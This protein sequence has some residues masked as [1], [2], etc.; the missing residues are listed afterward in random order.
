MIAIDVP[1]RNIAGCCDNPCSD[2]SMNV[3]KDVPQEL[4]LDAHSQNAAANGER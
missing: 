1:H 2:V 4:M 3:C